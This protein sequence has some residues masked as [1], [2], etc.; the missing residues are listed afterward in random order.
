MKCKTSQRAK[1]LHTVIEYTE[2]TVA[3]LRGR[4]LYSR[5]TVITV[6]IAKRYETR[7]YWGI[8]RGF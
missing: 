4:M 5:Y 6:L 2:V 3:S 8:R 1:R 7:S